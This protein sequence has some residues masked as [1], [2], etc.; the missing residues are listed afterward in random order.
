M[1]KRLRKKLRLKALN[2]V[3]LGLRPVKA[4]SIDWDKACASYDR[5]TLDE[6]AQSWADYLDNQ[7]IEMF[8]KNRDVV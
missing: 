6:A 1:K 5:K 3:Y 8:G 7:I 4:D 2:R